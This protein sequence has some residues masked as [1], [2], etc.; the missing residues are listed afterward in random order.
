MIRHCL[1]LLCTL[2]LWLPQAEA[3]RLRISEGLPQ[4]LTPV[5][6][7]LEDPG[8]SL[9][10]NDVRGAT[11]DS[12]PEG[13]IDFGYSTSLFWLSFTV[14][15]DTAAAQEVLLHFPDSH[16]EALLVYDP[17]LI[18]QGDNET[19][20]KARPIPDR[21]IAIPLTFEAGESRT[22][23]M[24]FGDTYWAE[25]PVQLTT[26]E[27][28]FETRGAEDNWL[29]IF[30]AVL[31]T[32]AIGNFFYFIAT[33][34]PVFILYVGL[35]IT[36]V[37]YCISVEGIGFQYLWPE[38]P[39]FNTISV[40]V[41]SSF[42]QLFMILFT[43]GF[44][45]LEAAPAWLTRWFKLLAGVV[46]IHALSSIFMPQQLVIQAGFL[47]NPFTTLSLIG[48][49][50]WLLIKGN[51][52]A[53][54]YLGGWALVFGITVYLNTA[55]LGLIQVGTTSLLAIQI[56]EI[57]MLFEALVFA[58]GVADQYRRL[59]EEN[60][61]QQ[62]ALVA[63]LQLRLE[64]AGERS[65]L[66]AEKEDALRQVLE[67]SKQLATTTHDLKQP[68]TS[69]SLA[70]DTV[71]KDVSNTPAAESLRSTLQD[72]DALIGTALDDASGSLQDVASSVMVDVDQLLMDT[73]MRFGDEA[74][75]K[76]LFIRV[77]A[78]A[79]SCQL[80]RIALNRCINN[81]VSN[82]IRYTET[83]GILL[84]ARRRGA[85]LLIQIYDTGVG[86][87]DSMS[88]AV[89]ELQTKSN[90]S[91]GHGLGLAI[92]KEIAARAGWEISCSST[93]GRGSVFSLTI[94]GVLNV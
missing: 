42:G 35:Q 6:T 69:L 72:I 81:L 89:F 62:E 10:I 53:R 54:Y 70:L 83:G 29:W 64:E 57:A 78:P 38:S 9:G 39:A 13:K 85:D 79:M 76:D 56:F 17:D 59:N 14:T 60:A 15:N 43:M 77:H 71:L 55:A 91:P 19:P 51:I 47:L 63:Q 21:K 48:Y 93:P 16:A 68:M 4:D 40:T 44:L 23:Y 18:F 87:D 12:L 75:A 67:N 80:P 36:T 30:I 82:A 58:L 41:F 8:G 84:A 20:F 52:N 66:E 61:E 73:A 88:K 2:A 25:F 37:L 74:R 32:L 27:A 86:M 5:V 33:K 11:F 24:R 65:K 28:F 22:I 1:Y 45:G 3:C 34:R 46:T 31:S 92:V 50:T 49:A 26:N 7:Y 94:P 90:T